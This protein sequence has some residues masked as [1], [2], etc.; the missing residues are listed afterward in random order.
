MTDVRTRRRPGLERVL[1]TAD[2]LFYDVGIHATG[3]DMIA[4]EA[5]VSKATMYT[6]FRTTDQLVAEYLRGRSGAWQAH[7]RRH[8][9]AMAPDPIERILAVFDLLG[10]WFRTAG[11]HGCPFINAEAES[12]PD[13]PVHEVNLAHRAWVRDLFT[14]LA[15]QAGAD[16]PP[17][18]VARQ[19][20]MLYDGAMSSAQA[21]P[22]VD[23]AG[24]ARDAARTLLRTPAV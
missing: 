23:W 12:S 19:L 2:R 20:V 6:Y 8:L 14:G 13:S 7:V 1:A 10:E 22:D 9:D 11:Y 4:A 17:D 16:A 21:E 3:V 18:V 24:P 5:G 15:E